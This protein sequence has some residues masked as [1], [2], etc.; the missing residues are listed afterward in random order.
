MS[1]K[2]L[3]DTRVIIALFQKDPAAEQLMTR[4]GERFLPVP[5]L[6][7]SMSGCRARDAPI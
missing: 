7:N 2:L 6:E 3:L 5:A 1:G 4:G